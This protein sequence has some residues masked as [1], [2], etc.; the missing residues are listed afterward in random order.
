MDLRIHFD[1]N[2]RRVS[3]LFDPNEFR[4]IH[5]IHENEIEEDLDHMYRLANE[6]NYSFNTK[7]SSIPNITVIHNEKPVDGVF[8]CP[9]CYEFH[10]KNKHVVTNCNHEFCGDCMSVILY[11]SYSDNKDASCPLCRQE[12]TLIEAASSQVYDSISVLINT[13]NNTHDEYH[14]GEDGIYN[15]NSID[16]FDI[17]HVFDDYMNS[18]TSV[19]RALSPEFDNVSISLQSPSPSPIV[20]N[21]ALLRYTDDDLDLAAIL[22][23]FHSLQRDMDLE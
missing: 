18:P 11:N 1:I 9:I 5:Y 4:D 14:Q 6:S 12:C 23:E 3:R 15:F 22:M 20:D 17:A 7:Q 13:C 16:Y 19:A 21:I 10:D 8:E 2:Y